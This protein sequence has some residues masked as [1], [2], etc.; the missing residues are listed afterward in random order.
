MN[1]YT[2][3]ELRTAAAGQVRN[4]SARARTINEAKA[5]HLRTAF[6]CHSHKDRTYALG[7][8]AVIESQG[9]SLYID[10]LDE[11]MPETPNRVTAERIQNKIVACDLFLFLATDNSMVSRWCPWEIGYANGKKPIDSIVIVPTK[12]D[13]GRFHGNEYLQLYRRFESS[14]VRVYGQP[15]APTIIRPGE[16]F[17]VNVSQL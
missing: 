13:L 2:Y 4:F 15:A 16:S 7:L 9:G 17:G 6:L 5:L 14:G 1:A 11:E 3:S 12:D 8:K 10:W